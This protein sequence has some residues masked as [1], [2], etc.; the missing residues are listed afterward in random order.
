MI[1]DCWMCDFDLEL[2]LLIHGFVEVDGYGEVLYHLQRDS[3]DHRTFMPPG[4]DKVLL[5][6]T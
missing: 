2:I 6:C 4:A 1:P 3:Q 5:H